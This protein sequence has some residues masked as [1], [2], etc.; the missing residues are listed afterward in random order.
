MS[1][2]RYVALALIA[3]SALA[4]AACDGDTAENNDYVEQVNAGQLDVAEQ[5][6]GRRPPTGGSP[7]QI[8]SALERVSAESSEPPPPI[9]TRSSPPRTSR[10]STT[11]SSPT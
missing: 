4:L 11:R 9:S 7:Q 5:R 10:S 6:Q 3:A 8:A 1:R 2:L